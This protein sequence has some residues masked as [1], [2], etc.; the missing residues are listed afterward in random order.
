MAKRDEIIPPWTV[1]KERSRLSN[2]QLVALD[3]GHF[4]PYKSPY[5]EEVVD[6]EQKFL[7]THLQST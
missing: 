4:D 1:Q 5:F 2:A 7:A 6:T 3:S